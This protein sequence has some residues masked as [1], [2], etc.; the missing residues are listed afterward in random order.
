MAERAN[1]VA[2]QEMLRSED[3][4]NQAQKQDVA[5]TRD[6]QLQKSNNELL[7]A[8][9]RL[10]ELRRE[11]G[12]LAQARL[13]QAKLEALAARERQLAERA[14]QASREQVKDADAQKKRTELQ[15]NQE[16]LAND[17]RRQTEQ[18]ETL[19]TAL[20]S[21]APT[22]PATWPNKRV[23]WP[24]LSVSWPA[25]SRT[26]GRPRNRASFDDLAH[27]Q[28]AVAEK[29]KE[30]ARETQPSTRAAHTEPLRT[31]EAARAVETLKQGK[32]K[33]PCS[34]RSRLPSSWT[35]SLANWSGRSSYR[36][37]RA[38][39]LTSWLAWRRT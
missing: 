38:R 13:A 7:S 14:V 9:K 34:S 29:A 32:R 27:R 23:N 11:N 36:M 33:R 4:M 37:T 5:E 17:L 25:P 24:R 15:R 16:E 20:E 31:E 10:E 2:Q 18:D 22:R 19:R 12:R 21:L 3:N 30:L 35:G 28:Q 39:R 8:V 26:R 1:D 6:L